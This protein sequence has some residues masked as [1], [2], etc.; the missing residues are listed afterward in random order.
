MTKV[1]DKSISEWKGIVNGHMKGETAEF[2]RS[3]LQGTESDCNEKLIVLL[4][5]LVDSVLH[6]LLW[7]L[8][9][10][11]ELQVSVT[12]GDDRVDNINLISD[13]LSGEMYGKNGWIKK[14]SK[15]SL[16]K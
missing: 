7:T 9:Q 12:I 10:S 6:H 8:E 5:K 2:A 15:E 4:P 3:I 14:F 16:N 11:Q 1:R 13:G